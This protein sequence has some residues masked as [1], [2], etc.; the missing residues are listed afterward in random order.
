MLGSGFVFGPPGSILRFWA[1][2]GVCAR[3]SF[4]RPGRKSPF[5]RGLSPRRVKLCARHCLFGIPLFFC[6]VSLFS[7]LRLAAKAGLSAEFAPLGRDGRLSV[8][9]SGVAP[10]S[11]RAVAASGAAC[12]F[13][14]LSPCRLS[15]RGTSHVQAFPSCYP[16]NGQRQRSVDSRIRDPE[17]PIH[18]RRA[19]PRG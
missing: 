14:L 18:P 17:D 12:F 3:L 15:A 10:A 5:G 11:D 13:S 16:R 1:K 4:C 2:S 7:N 19:I 9:F 8:F 6:L